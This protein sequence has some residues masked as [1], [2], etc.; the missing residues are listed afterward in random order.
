MQ[1]SLGRNGE[2]SLIK[3]AVELPSLPLRIV[4]VEHGIVPLFS[5]TILV[6]LILKFLT[7]LT[8]IF[9]FVL[10]PFLLPSGLPV[11]LLFCLSASL[12]AFLLIFLW[13]RLFSVC[14]QVLPQLSAL[15]S[16][17][18]ARFPSKSCKVKPLLTW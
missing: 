9:F 14:S 5:N 16:P 2:D 17:H 10:S 6:F 8:L 1:S 7:L 18:S 11:S 3:H 13:L 12:P 15:W 4:T